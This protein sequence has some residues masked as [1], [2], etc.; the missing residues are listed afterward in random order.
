MPRPA[1]FPS[2]SVPSPAA[3]MTAPPDRRPRAAL[4]GLI[5]TLVLTVA[6]GVPLLWLGVPWLVLLTSAAPALIL[7]LA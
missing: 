6:L 2:H 7:S 1:A 3:P 4:A 5:T